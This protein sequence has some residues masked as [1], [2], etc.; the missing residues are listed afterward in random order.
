MCVRQIWQ[1][2]PDKLGSPSKLTS[3]PIRLFNVDPLRR[4]WL[5]NDKI[6]TLSTTPCSPKKGTEQ[7]KN[8]NDEH[9]LT[10]TTHSCCKKRSAG[11]LI[12]WEKLGVFG[13]I[14][15]SF[16]SEYTHAPRTLSGAFWSRWC[17][18]KKTLKVQKEG[19]QYTVERQLAKPANGRSLGK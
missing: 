17:L 9:L 13:E 3:W 8:K 14:R 15:L 6:P 1:C 2:A 4:D 19:A 5:R 11:H 10:K 18:E 7:S 16:L 12:G